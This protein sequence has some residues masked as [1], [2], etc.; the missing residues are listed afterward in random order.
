MANTMKKIVEPRIGSY[1]ISRTKCNKMFNSSTDNKIEQK[2]NPS[3]RHD[4][5][6]LIA[7]I[8][9]SYYFFFI[10]LPLQVFVAVP[11]EP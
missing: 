1:D 11:H 4:K 3:G 10:V 5:N 2:E 7:V 8:N 6:M 9:R